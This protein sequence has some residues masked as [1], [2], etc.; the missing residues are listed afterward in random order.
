MG[1]ELNFWG[2]IELFDKKAIKI[3]SKLIEKEESPFAEYNDIEF[4]EE[5]P[6]IRI[7]CCWKSYENEMEKLC[8]FVAMLDKEAKGII[9]CSGEEDD[10][11]WRIIVAE[12]KLEIERGH[13][14]YDKGDKFEDKEIKKKVY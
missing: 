7:N 4:E 3:I 5:I 13:I 9:T 10:D 1:Y 14:V 2:N 12:G 11:S 6:E 8:L